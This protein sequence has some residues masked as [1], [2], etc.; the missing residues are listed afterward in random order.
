MKQRI[1]LIIF[2]LLASHTTGVQAK[3]KW[4]AGIKEDY[5]SRFQY[6]LGSDG[7]AIVRRNLFDMGFESITAITRLAMMGKNESQVFQPV[8]RTR[9]SDMETLMSRVIQARGEFVIKP[10]I[11][12]NPEYGIVSRLT[13]IEPSDPRLWFSTYWQAYAPLIALTQRREVSEL[14]LGVGLHGL[15]KPEFSDAWTQL[16]SEAERRSAAQTRL[17]IEISSHADLIAFEHWKNQNPTGYGQFTSH[18]SRI[19]IASALAVQPSVLS[20]AQSLFPG[21]KITLANTIVPACRAYYLEED[22]GFCTPHSPRDDEY[23]AQNLDAWFRW[24]TQISE[25][26]RRWIAEVEFLAATTDPEPDLERADPRFLYFNPFIKDVFLRN[27]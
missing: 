24:F 13:G 2:L 4:S 16:A 1:R 11:F 5:V 23:Q 18:L 27:R 26:Q 21:K 22:E 10:V 6:H 17:S 9:L 25:N 19:R 7:V 12:L 20:K 3:I 15:W 14:V 8:S